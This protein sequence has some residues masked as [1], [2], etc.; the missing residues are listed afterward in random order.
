MVHKFTNKEYPEDQ[1]KFELFNLYAANLYIGFFVALAFILLYGISMR[2]NIFWFCLF[3]CLIAVALVP[4]FTFVRMKNV[5]VE[6]MVDREFVCIRS[7]YD[8]FRDTE[9]YFEHFN[10]A[11]PKLQ[12]NKLTINYQNRIVELDGTNWPNFYQLATELQVI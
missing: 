9:P 3:A 8:I 2:F 1:N 6:V 11:M 10:V 12:G 4:T 5:I 7:V